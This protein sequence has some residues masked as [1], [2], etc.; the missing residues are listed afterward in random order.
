MRKKPI[1]FTDLVSEAINKY[2]VREGHS[3]REKDPDYWMVLDVPNTKPDHRLVVCRDGIQIIHQRFTGGRWRG[4]H[5]Y[6]SK[7]GL[8]GGLSAISLSHEPSYSEAE[9]SLRPKEIGKGVA[10]GIEFATWG[11]WL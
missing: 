11:G 9:T 10:K 7:S 1:Q 6:A 2:G 5:S 4:E 8:K 3:H